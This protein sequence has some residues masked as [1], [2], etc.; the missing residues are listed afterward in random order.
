M[1]AEPV[2]GSFPLPALMLILD[3]LLGA[4]VL[5]LVLQPLVEPDLGWHLRAGLDLI[6]Q[7]W[8]LPD[9]D[10]YSHT[11]PDWH[12]VEHAWLTDGLLGL[13]YRMLEP[14]GGLGLIAFFGG[15]TA[16]AWWIAAGVASVHR[17]C[18]LA[19]MVASLW[20]ALPFL[21][22]RTQLIS[23][24]G[25]A[26]VLT[27]WNRMQRGQPQWVWALPPLFLLWA[28]LHGGFTA[29]L[30]LITV[31][32]SLSFLVKICVEWKVVQAPR[33][34]PVLS[35]DVIRLCAFAILVSFA[36][37]CLN[38]YG[39]RL[40]VE[41]YES[42][43]DRFMIDTL[44]EWQPVSFHGWAGRAYGFYLLGFIGLMAGWYRRVEPVRWVLLA[45]MLG[46]SLLHWRNVTL[47]LIV[48][49][50]LAAELGAAAA[51]SFLRR[52][53]VLQAHAAGTVLV[54]S[55]M[56]ATALYAL[57]TEHLEHVWQSGRTPDRYFE[58]TEYPIEAVRWIRAHRDETGTRLYNDYSYGGFL[59]WQLPGERIF[60]DGR[61][62]AWRIKDRWIFHDYVELNREDS[63]QLALLDRYGVD[64]AMIPRGSALAVALEAHPAWKNVYA[65]A[66]VVIV[67][68]QS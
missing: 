11:M 63:P 18:R 50:P 28:N 39:W 65:D 29:G 62:P 9:T 41:I 25:V 45:L 3:V 1:K 15:V 38:P 17:T 8:R 7:G 22:A 47:F 4:F 13:I 49:L 23:L 67:R 48:S 27:I 21:G 12:W 60:I 6:A 36:V 58:R 33:D 26:V 46:L 32:L 2:R 5:N 37:T 34:E 44:R 56:A 52:V 57:G 20:V 40:Y 35:W 61:M 19:A 51:D 53:P 66:K 31:L 10:P 16:L 59:L 30:F 43:T 68:R 42:L 24:L 14:S 64:W 54:V 55:I